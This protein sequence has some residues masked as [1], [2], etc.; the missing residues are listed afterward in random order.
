MGGRIGADSAEGAGSTFWFTLPLREASSAPPV[1]HPGGLAGRR[2]LV[3]DDNATNREILEHHVQAGGMRATT[4]A[5]GRIALQQL[6][7]ALRDGDPYDLAIIDMKMPGMDGIELATAIRTDGAF[8]DL[9]L[10]LVTSLHSTDE[11]G[12]A[13]EVG[14]S[15]YLSKP[16]RRQELYRALAQAGGGLPA[17]AAPAPGPAQV[18]KIH[19]RVLMAED[20][21]VNQVVARNMLKSLGCEWEIVANGQAALQAVQQRAFDIV[22]MDCQMPVMDGYAASR[23]IRAW[24]A[25]SPDRPRIPIVALTANA[26]VGDAE[27]CLAAGMDEHLAKPYTRRQLG[28]AMARWLPA[29]LVESD[30]GEAV[31]PAATAPAE[32]K[33]SLIDANALDNIRALDDGSG[34]SVL[35]EVIGI[36]LAEAPGHLQGL[37]AGLAAG[38]AAELGRIAHAFKSASFNVGAMPLGELCRQLERLGKAGEMHGAAELVAHIERMFQRVRPLLLAE[39]KAAA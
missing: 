20:N 13:K 5:S 14:F 29:R 27:A 1:P 36:F 23:A 32:D 10:V 19:A 4:A 28:A 24:E 37:Q 3:V 8:G 33:D 17:D 16:V 7:A 39:M 12:R 2:A 34:E 25:A 21:G 15:A 31:A 26:L 6:H 35:D 18:A 22:L 38:H 9:R 30:G 11:M